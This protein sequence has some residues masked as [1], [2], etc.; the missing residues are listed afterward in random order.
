[1]KIRAAPWTAS[2]GR[3]MRSLAVFGCLGPAGSSLAGSYMAV[4][5]EMAAVHG[6]DF[7]IEYEDRPRD[8][9]ANQALTVDQATPY[10]RAA[11]DARVKPSCRMPSCRRSP[12]GVSR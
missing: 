9:I 6:H 7:A 11:D 5:R 2:V 3:I 12:D 4:P 8:F 1:M 10:L